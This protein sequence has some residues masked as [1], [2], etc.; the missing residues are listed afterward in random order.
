MGELFGKVA[1]GFGKASVFL[2]M[3][4]YRVPLRNLLGRNPYEGTLNVRVNPL[5]KDNLLRDLSPIV[6]P[7][8]TYK[9]KAYFSLRCYKVMIKEIGCLII[10]PEKTAHDPEI[11]EVV[12]GLN[13]REALHLKDNDAINI[14]AI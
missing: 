13:L 1:S 4:Q 6:I 10:I 11:V 12:S 8:F 14:I 2:S 5:A 9:K 3:D 7:G